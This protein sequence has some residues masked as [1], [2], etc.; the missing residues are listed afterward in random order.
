[1]SQINIDCPG[2]TLTD[3]FAGVGRDAVAD[4]CL[5]GVLSRPWSIIVHK[6]YPLPILILGKTHLM[7]PVELRKH[8]LKLLFGD[9]LRDV[10]NVEG[11]HLRASVDLIAL[12]YI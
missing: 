12:N 4:R 10:A 6:G 5:H 8:F 3:S 2:L 11:K 7:E 1:M 9:I